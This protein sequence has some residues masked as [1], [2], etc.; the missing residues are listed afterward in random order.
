MLA[1]GPASAETAGMG[2]Q[3]AE[4]GSPMA[5]APFVW[6]L[7]IGSYERDGR[8]GAKRTAQSWLLLLLSNLVC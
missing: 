8:R 2:L 7:G 1:V 6:L 4:G 3:G 5:L